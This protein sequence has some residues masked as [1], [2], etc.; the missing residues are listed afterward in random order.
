MR[1]VPLAALQGTAPFTLTFE[2]TGHLD[3]NADGR[4]PASIDHAW[5]YTLTL[6]RVDEGGR[7]P[8]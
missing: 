5:A 4:T 6:Q 8:G 2:G 3:V 1:R 7:P